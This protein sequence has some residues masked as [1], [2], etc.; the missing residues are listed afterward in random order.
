MFYINRQNFLFNQTI[1]YK[2][3]KYLSNQIFNKYLYKTKFLL[4]YFYLMLFII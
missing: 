1:N 2:F 3:I 4:F